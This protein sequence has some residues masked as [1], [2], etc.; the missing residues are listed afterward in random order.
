MPRLTFYCE[1]GLTSSCVINFMDV[2]LKLCMWSNGKTNT[3][4]RM[5]HTPSYTWRLKSSGLQS[6]LKTLLMNMWII[7]RTFGSP[8]T[9]SLH[10][11]W[12]H[13]LQRLN[14]YAVWVCFCFQHRNIFFFFNAQSTKTVVSRQIPTETLQSDELSSPSETAVWTYLTSEI[15]A[16]TY[17][18]SETAVWIYLS[19]SPTENLQSYEFISYRNSSLS[20]TEILQSRF[21]SYR[22]VS[23]VQ[24]HLR[25]HFLQRLQSE[26]ISYRDCSLS[27]SPTETAVW[28]CCLPRLQSEF[29][30]YRDSSLSSF[31]TDCSL[32][33]PST[34]TSVHFI[35]RLQSEF[36]SYRDCSLSLSSTKTAVWVC[37]LQRWQSEF[38]S[39][40][41]CSLSFSPTETAVQV[42]LLQRLQSEFV[43]YRCCSLSSIPT[44]TAVWVYLLHRLQSE[45][46]SNR[47]CS[48]S[49]CPTET[50]VLVC[51][52]E[53]LHILSKLSIPFC[54]R[55]GPSSITAVSYTHLTLPTRST[56]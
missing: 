47:G 26:F 22:G 45:F 21:V 20:P 1:C 28:V 17:L 3:T 40:G 8:P 23:V 36:V 11:V 41:D 30:S 24:L 7:H 53:R 43:S 42:H 46:I 29:V 12:V 18:S 54:A 14:N 32:S 37:L 27:M 51:V 39:Y 52:L 56:V 48:L 9:E 19:Q 5:L 31:P 55:K 10:A 2:A 49:L 38:I 34:K 44:E 15:A 16:G 25:V 33:L 6:L 4:Q 13:L 50:A 35:Q